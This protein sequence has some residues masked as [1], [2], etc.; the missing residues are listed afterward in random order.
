MGN[1]LYIYW[2]VIGLLAG[3]NY[4]PTATNAV[5]RSAEAV[6]KSDISVAHTVN[7]SSSAMTQ[8]YPLLIGD[9]LSVEYINVL[10]KARSPLLAA[11]KTDGRQYI[12]GKMLNHEPNFTIIGKFHEGLGGFGIDAKG[13]ISPGVYGI[14]FVGSKVLNDKEFLLMFDD[15]DL[16][17]RYVGNLDQFVA[18][19]TIAGKYSDNKGMLYSFSID[20]QATFP[21]RSF[22]YIVASDVIS[23]CDYFFEVI[24]H[25]GGA[26]YGFKFVKN[27]LQLFRMGGPMGDEPEP[28]PF[29]TLIRIGDAE[30]KPTK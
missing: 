11:E 20:G 25:G 8:A 1:K 24:P 30:T 5:S 7:A 22:Q 9:Y 6:N 26:Q 10:Q 29:V 16:L 14:K 13:E 4:E 12:V 19:Q 3:C 17:Y 27:E 2:F 21:D 18:T 28:N 15:K 23:S